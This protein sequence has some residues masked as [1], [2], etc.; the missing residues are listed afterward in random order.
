KTTDGCHTWTLLF[1]NPDNDG[2]FDAIH[3]SLTTELSRSWVLGDPV[4]GQFAL[5]EISDTGKRAT[6]QENVG[7]KASPDQQGAFAASNSSLF[8][9]ANGNLIFASGGA[10]GA[11]VY[12]ETFRY[13]CKESCV[14]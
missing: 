7:L 5:F 12:R 2:F 13:F 3:S 4:N 14:F 9:L 6:R 1:K 11:K 8:R 10:A